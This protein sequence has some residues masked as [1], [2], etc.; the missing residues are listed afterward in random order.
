MQTKITDEDLAQ[1][2][3]KLVSTQAVSAPN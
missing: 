1:L 3:E 2:E